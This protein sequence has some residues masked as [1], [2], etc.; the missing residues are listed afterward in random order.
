[1][2]T[3]TGVNGQV[4][5]LQVIG[6]EFLAIAEGYDANYHRFAVCLKRKLSFYES[7]N[8][9]NTSIIVVQVSDSQIQE[10][11]EY[12]DNI[13]Q[14]FPPRGE[15]GKTALEKLPGPKIIDEI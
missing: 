7:R 12:F 14:M 15:Q 13:M 10:A 3:W 2:L 4:F 11:V 1:M 5:K 8:Q 6:Y 9:A